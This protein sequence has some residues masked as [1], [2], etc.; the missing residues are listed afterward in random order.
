MLTGDNKEHLFSC[1]KTQKTLFIIQNINIKII[2]GA[3]WTSILSLIVCNVSVCLA[4][5]LPSFVDK[6]PR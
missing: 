3:N 2:A 1:N 6:H 4:Y 5:R